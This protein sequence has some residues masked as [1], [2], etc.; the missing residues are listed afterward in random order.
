MSKD[1]VSFVPGAI[2]A[3]AMYTMTEL[4]ARLSW[5]VNTL[6]LALN[7]GLRFYRFAD[8]TYVFGSDVMRFIK[9]CGESV[10]D[11]EQ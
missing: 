5:S 9:E 2:L 7:K 8:I 1:K 4:C 6:S 3:D 11:G 10:K